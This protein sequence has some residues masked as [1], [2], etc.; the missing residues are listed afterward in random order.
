[1]RLCHVAAG[2]FTLLT[3][4]AGSTPFATELATALT[5]APPGAGARLWLDGGRIGAAVVPCHPAEL[6]PAARTMLTAVAPDG[7]R[8]YTGREWSARGTGFRV[9]VAY[10]D[11]AHIRSVLLADDGAVL[12]RSHTVPLT[13]VPQH[14][15][16]TALR[17][18]PFVDE[19]WIVSGPQHE[20]HWELLL[21]ERSGALHA[22]RIGLDGR[23]LAHRRRLDARVDG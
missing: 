19:A 8:R 15:L 14:V 12:E 22:V 6:P 7:E 5:T 21:R 2:L 16:A 18:A 9:E 10:T 1:M 4:C 20:E 17:S 13:E 3:A 23:A 11:P